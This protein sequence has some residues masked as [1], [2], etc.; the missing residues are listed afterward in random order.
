[1]AEEGPPTQVLG[2]GWLEQEA[3]LLVLIWPQI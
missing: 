3:G 2:L 1:M